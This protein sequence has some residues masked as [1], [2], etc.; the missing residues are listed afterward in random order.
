[1]NSKCLWIFLGL[2]F[3]AGIAV[4]EEGDT[5][6]PKC[7][8]YAQDFAENSDLLNETQLKQLQ[9]CITKILEQRY[10][11]DPPGLLKGTIIEK[12]L[13]SDEESGTIPQAPSPNP[14]AR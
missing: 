11:T 10:K 5:R 9:F 7:Q 6:S 8:K 12:P 2:V 1:L 14:G 3:C 13:S 4:A